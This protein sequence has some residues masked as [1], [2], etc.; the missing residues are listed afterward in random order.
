MWGNNVFKK[1]LYT[2]TTSLLLT[3]QAYAINL[4]AESYYIVEQDTGSVVL[5]KNADLQMGPASLTK[6][7]TAYLL[8]EAIERGDLTLETM[9]PRM[10][11]FSGLTSSR[12]S[13]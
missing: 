11:P 13:P 7:M 9:M 10:H 1:A 2:L 4:N 3:T 12:F 5:E 6:M 8:F